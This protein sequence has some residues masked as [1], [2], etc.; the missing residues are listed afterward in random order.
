[1]QIPT[2]IPMS[3]KV[4]RRYDPRLKSLVANSEARLGKI[5]LFSGL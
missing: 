2:V 1:M 3:R 5:K 4:Y